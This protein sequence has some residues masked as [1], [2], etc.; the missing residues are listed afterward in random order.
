M[1]F[2]PWENHLALKVNIYLIKLLSVLKF[3]QSFCFLT[4]CIKIYLSHKNINIT[5]NS[6][7]LLFLIKVSEAEQRMNFRL[8]SKRVART[9]MISTT[10]TR[11]SRTARSNSRR[12]CA[13]SFVS[14][15]WVQQVGPC[16]HTV[17][18]SPGTQNVQT[19]LTNIIQ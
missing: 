9:R 17:R 8:P 13:C 6:N 14:I 3:L 16:G 11:E 19:L 4:F 10:L 5:Y 2:D 12:L 15:S 7:Y 1:H 18:W